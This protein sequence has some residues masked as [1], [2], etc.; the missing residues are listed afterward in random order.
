MFGSEFLKKFRKSPDVP[1]T[2]KILS[3]VIPIFETDNLD[4]RYGAVFKC[5]FIKIRPKY[6]KNEDFGLLVHELTHF[7]QF[8]KTFGLFCYLY[9]FVEKLRVNW[10]IEA[11]A[12][13]ILVYLKRRARE[14]EIPL[15]K[16]TLEENKEIKKLEDF[17]IDYFANFMAVDGRYKKK[18]KEKNY[19]K[20]YI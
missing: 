9:G 12:N 19:L 10:E 11:Y 13:Q 16:Y 15:N 18:L 17:Y 2:S 4:K 5:F 1:K 3:Y 20:M 7:K 14:L 8:L 6:V